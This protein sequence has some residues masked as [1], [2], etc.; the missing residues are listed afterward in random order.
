MATAVAAG[1]SGN[2]NSWNLST[3]RPHDEWNIADN[4]HGSWKAMFPSRA[5]GQ[6]NLVWA[7]QATAS[8]PIEAISDLVVVAL[9]NAV[10]LPLL[11]VARPRRK[12]VFV[13][14]GFFQFKP[15]RVSSNGDR[16]DVTG[17]FSLKIS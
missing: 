16:C 7:V 10:I 1:V 2:R 9:T 14:R 3:D 12:V 17:C 13:T 11:L 8:L 6:A 5:T 15:N 4:A